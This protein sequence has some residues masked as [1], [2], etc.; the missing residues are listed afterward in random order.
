MEE[1]GKEAR[2]MKCTDIRT[3]SCKEREAQVQFFSFVA[4]ALCP[5]PGQRFLYTSEQSI[6]NAVTSWKPVG[7]EGSPQLPNFVGG[8]A[9]SPGQAPEGPVWLLPFALEAASSLHSLSSW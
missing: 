6:Q 9:A 4:S 2:G 8:P 5:C 7:F 3:T 1:Q